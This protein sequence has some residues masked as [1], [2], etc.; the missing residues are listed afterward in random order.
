L[1]RSPRLPNPA[2]EA[3]QSE[4]ADDM[5]GDRLREVR[6]MLG[7]TQASLARFLGGVNVRTVR[8]WE[9]ESDAYPIPVAVSVALELMVEY[10]V[11]PAKAYLLATGE[12]FEG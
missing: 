6:E 2:A 1:N 5:T 4:Q 7:L 8:R 9:S 10:R 3:C 11:S 12:V